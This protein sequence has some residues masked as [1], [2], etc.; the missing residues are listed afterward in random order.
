MTILCDLQTSVTIHVVLVTLNTK[1]PLL[2]RCY[3]LRCQLI[4]S[5]LRTAD[6]LCF[7][8]ISI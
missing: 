5:V 2:H 3:Q 7:T 6:V 1:L 4:E 8:D